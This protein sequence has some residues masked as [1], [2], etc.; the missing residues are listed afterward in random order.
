MSNKTS[1]NWSTIDPTEDALSAY[2]WM[3][4]VVITLFCFLFVS[5]RRAKSLE[6]YEQSS[7]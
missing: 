7:N 4:L 5:F 6:L 1:S 3:P 2:I